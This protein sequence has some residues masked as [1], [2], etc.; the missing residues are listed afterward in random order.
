MNLYCSFSSTTPNNYYYQVEIL[1]VDTAPSSS[2]SSSWSLSVGVVR[3]SELKKG[4]GTKGM[5]YNGNLTNGSAALNVGYGPRLKPGD[6]VV[7]EYQ[8]S[9]EDKKHRVKYHVNGTFFGT[10]FEISQ[11]D[12]MDKETETFVPCLHCQ[13][14]IRV[15]TQVQ[16]TRQALCST[17]ATAERTTNPWE[18]DWILVQA[19]KAP[20]SMNEQ[21]K[22]TSIWLLEESQQGSPDQIL[23]LHMETHSTDETRIECAMVV[24]VCNSM[25][26]I[27]RISPH[28]LE[29]EADSSSDPGRLEY[30]LENPE[31]EA[32]PSIVVAT[33]MMPPPALFEV[34]QDLSQALAVDWKVLRVASDGMTMQ[35]LSREGW[36][37]GQFQRRQLDQDQVAC[38]SYS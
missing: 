35:A 16:L 25:R 17:L 15:Q 23:T 37:L 36:V 14:Q 20:G 32:L 22:M 6:V 12:S 33:R 19:W 34:E 7:V 3:P 13:G 5:F 31:G 2:S 30:T 21:D 10:A 24:K 4:W 1:S 29:G 28:V 18:G 11:Q 9:E 38:T 26:V 27:K 8:Y